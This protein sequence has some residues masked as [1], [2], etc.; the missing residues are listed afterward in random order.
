MA[1]IYIYAIL[2]KCF[3]FKKYL[4]FKIIM[5]SVIDH[6]VPQIMW[7]PTEINLTKSFYLF[8]FSTSKVSF[9]LNT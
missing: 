2:Q 7:V 4:Y 5:F 3:Y 8:S 1:Y 9:C 6:T